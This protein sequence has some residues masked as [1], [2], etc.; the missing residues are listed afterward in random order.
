MKP[1][2][3]QVMACEERKHC[4]ICR[5]S[6]AFR[7]ILKAKGVVEERDFEC[8]FGVPWA[9]PK[10]DAY[11]QVR[12]P[13]WA[14]FIAEHATGADAGVGDTVARHFGVAGRAFKA[15]FATTFRRSCGCEERRE[16]LNLKYP[17]KS[18][19]AGTGHH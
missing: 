1:D 14:R 11:D 4:A 8:P 6:G 18:R 19:D 2:L 10:L 3:T 17:Y 15:W 5:S 16:V 12:W 9:V 13:A 7:L